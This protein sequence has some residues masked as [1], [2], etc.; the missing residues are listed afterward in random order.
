MENWGMLSRL[1]ELKPEGH[2]E[3]GREEKGFPPHTG[4]KKLS[5]KVRHFK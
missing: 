2:T 1:R 3:R 4:E 5:Q